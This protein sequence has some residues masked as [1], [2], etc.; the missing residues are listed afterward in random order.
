M[1]L[2]DYL[3]LFPGAS[4]EK[5]KFMALAEAVLSQ[6]TD[7]QHVVAEIRAGYAVGQAEGNQLDAFA[8]SVGLRRETGAGDEA[9]RQFLLAKLALWTWDGTNEKV[10]TALSAQPGVT[11]TDNSDGTVT[12]SP[13][14]TDPELAPVPAGVRIIRDGG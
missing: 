14:G 13:A 12:V 6:V 5:T 4:R 1:Q 11:V 10:P 8:E 7:L 9:F 2:S 3:H